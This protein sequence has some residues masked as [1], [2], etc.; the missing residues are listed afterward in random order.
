MGESE[1]AWWHKISLVSDIEDQEPYF[2]TGDHI[3]VQVFFA[4]RVFAKYWT[5]LDNLCNIGI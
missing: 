1:A 4:S 2:P 3:F 5:H